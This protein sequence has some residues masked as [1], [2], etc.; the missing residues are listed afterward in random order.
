[1]DMC[2]YTFVD[3]S[4]VD[5]LDILERRLYQDGH[6]SRMKLNTW[7]IESRVPI[8]A[9]DMVINHKKRKRIDMEAYK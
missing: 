6:N 8:Q 1:M 7:L 3:P 5:K 2:E 4:S 9:A